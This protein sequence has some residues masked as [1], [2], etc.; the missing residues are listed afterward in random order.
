MLPAALAGIL[1]VHLY[2]VVRLG[3]SHMPK[4]DE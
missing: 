4:K 3:I 1:G 2:L